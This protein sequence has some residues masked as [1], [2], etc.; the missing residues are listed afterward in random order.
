VN[1]LSRLKLVL[2]MG[3]VVLFLLGIICLPAG[4]GL[5]PKRNLSAFNNLAD[6]GAFI[7]MGLV[8]MGIGLV[9]FFISYFVP[10]E[11]DP[12]YWD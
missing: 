11:S 8:L 3:G 1:L 12:D 10:G 4:Y 6:L 9:A 2:Q 5:S 7:K